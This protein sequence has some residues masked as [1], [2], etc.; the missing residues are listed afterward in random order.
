MNRNPGPAFPGGLDTAE[1]TE[2]LEK[3]LEKIP[4]RE[5]KMQHWGDGP[6]NKAF[7]A[8]L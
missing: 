2:Y 5:K 4:Q 7:V 3:S 8:Q 1:R 6:M